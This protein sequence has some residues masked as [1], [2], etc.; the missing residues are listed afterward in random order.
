MLK[1]ITKLKL[2]KQSIEKSLMGIDTTDT[3]YACGQEIDNSK[4]KQLQKDLNKDL[5]ETIHKL[6]EWSE[7]KIY[8]KDK[9]ELYQ[10]TTQKFNKNQKAIEQF[11]QLT[12]MIDE[13]L[14]IDHPNI[15]QLKQMIEE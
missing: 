15:D 12:R 14:P 2:H 9:V 4:A 5:F 1:Q 6:E 7:E 8:A 3:C 11:E 10:E 13:N